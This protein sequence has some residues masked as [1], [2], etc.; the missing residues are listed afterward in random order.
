[1]ISYLR[2]GYVEAEEKGHG[3]TENGRAPNNGIDANE[4]ADGD[5]PGEFLWS[6][7]EAEER[8]D[9]QGSAPVEPVVMDGRGSWFDTGGNG[10]ALIHY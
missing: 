9:R 10:L 8:K 3:E 6:R 1:M 2:G 7:S 4:K 5:A